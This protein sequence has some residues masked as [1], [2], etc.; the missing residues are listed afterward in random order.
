MTKIKEDKINDFLKKLKEEHT[1]EKE[2]W[3]TPI[4]TNLLITE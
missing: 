4:S 1:K 3:F 2:K